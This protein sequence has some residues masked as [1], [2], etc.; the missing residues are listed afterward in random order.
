MRV[1]YL[2]KKYS[3]YIIEQNLIVFEEIDETLPSDDPHQKSNVDSD[4]VTYI[5]YSDVKRKLEL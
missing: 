1:N 2:V 4:D 5:V 3:N